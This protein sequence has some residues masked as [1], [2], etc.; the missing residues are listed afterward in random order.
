[1]NKKGQNFL[2]YALLL[3]CIALALTAMQVYF[4][5]GIQGVIKSTSDDLVLP[6]QDFYGANGQILGMAEEMVEGV[7]YRQLM[8]TTNVKDQEIVTTE[9]ARG[10]RGFVINRDRVTSQGSWLTT[11]EVKSPL[12]DYDTLT[13][14]GSDPSPTFSENVS[15][16]GNGSN[17]A[18]GM[19]SAGE[20]RAVIKSGG[21]ITSQSNVLNGGVQVRYGGTEATRSAPITN[22]NEVRNINANLNTQGH[23]AGPSGSG[24]FI[25]S[26]SKISEIVQSSYA[27]SGQRDAAA[28]SVNSQ[29]GLGR[30]TS[31]AMGAA[32]NGINTFVYGAPPTGNPA[33]SQPLVVDGKPYQVSIIGIA[34]QPSATV[35]A[36]SGSTGAETSTSA[37][38]HWEPAYMAGTDAGNDLGIDPDAKTWVPA[39]SPNTGTGNTDI[40]AAFRTDK[41]RPT[42]IQQQPVPA[43]M[44]QNGSVLSGDWNKQLTFTPKVN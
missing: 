6:A 15:S 23:S 1:M 19:L 37:G 34:P 16:A 11:L 44:K 27:N 2:E 31:N 40:F 13:E 35:T 20:M 33:A 22:A 26:G 10:E 5:R 3:G 28:G 18:D 30:G 43:I 8:P 21:T 9:R 24:T 42:V 29:F 39:A 41:T 17:G 38:G 32:V 4:K 7:S 14:K 36:A 25:V 12:P